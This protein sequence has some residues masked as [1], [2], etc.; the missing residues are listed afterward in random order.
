MAQSLQ[1]ESNVISG[2]VKPPARPW[3]ERTEMPD[4]QKFRRQTHGH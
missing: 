4:N 2:G 3:T 1:S